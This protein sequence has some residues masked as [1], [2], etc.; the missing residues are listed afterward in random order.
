MAAIMIKD[1]PKE[2]HQWLKEEAS[3]NRRSM[4]QQLLHLID[5]A[6]LR[7][8]KPI[9]PPLRIKTRKPFTQKW[10]R[11]AIEEGRE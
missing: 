8:L 6:R 5:Q 1:V 2:A 10:L 4:K 3:R 7:P 9:P 11:K